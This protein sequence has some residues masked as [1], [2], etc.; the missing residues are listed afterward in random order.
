MAEAPNEV[1]SEYFDH[2]R[3][4]Y[5]DGYHVGETVDRVMVMMKTA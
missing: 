3:L 1:P 2:G 4:D 5:S